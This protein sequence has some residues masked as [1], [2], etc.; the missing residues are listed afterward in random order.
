[1]APIR[2]VVQRTI[3]SDTKATTRSGVE[4]RTTKSVRR[5]ARRVPCCI[6]W[7]RAYTGSVAVP[8]RR[9][10]GRKNPSITN[11]A[12]WYL[13]KRY[14]SEG[15]TG[16]VYALQKLPP[17]HSAESVVDALNAAVAAL[18]PEQSDAESPAIWDNPEELWVTHNAQICPSTLSTATE[19][20]S[21]TASPLLDLSTFPN[22]DASRL[23]QAKALFGESTVETKHLSQLQTCESGSAT[24]DNFL[25][26]LPTSP[27]NLF[28]PILPVSTDLDVKSCP[29][30]LS[31]VPD[32]RYPPFQNDRTQSQPQVRR[33]VRMEDLKARAATLPQ[34]SVNPPQRTPTCLRVGSPITG[35]VMTRK[36]LAK[37]SLKIRIPKNRNKE[38]LPRSLQARDDGSALNPGPDVEK[39]CVI[40]AADVVKDGFNSELEPLDSDLGNFTCDFSSINSRDPSRARRAVVQGKKSKESTTLP[41]KSGSS[42]S[43]LASTSQISI[44][45]TNCS[46]RSS[47]KKYGSSRH[48]DT[49]K[50]LPPLP[51]AFESMKAGHRDLESVAMSNATLK[52]LLA[53]ECDASDSKKEMEERIASKRL[54]DRS[55]AVIQGFR[56]FTHRSF[57]PL[58]EDVRSQSDGTLWPQAP[59]Q[60]RAAD[61][62]GVQKRAA[63]EASLA[64]RKKKGRGIIF[65]DDGPWKAV[66]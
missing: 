8:R 38:S 45:Q 33:K 17:S 58:P 55:A 35:P 47:I 16:L 24:A 32:S 11:T 5:R 13:D 44:T 63:S 3:S 7:P 66:R 14:P 54:S 50:D 12:Q 28:A 60:N 20:T 49:T 18:E 34:L 64:I 23:S 36:P 51:N 48:V 10:G 37:D 29:D 9:E 40:T 22:T 65:A 56:D 52:A 61:L 6:P 26:S 53:A 30:Q 62:S 57:F 46:S 25:S 1:M 31:C 41:S 15:P 27:P 21:T 59:S 2:K 43:D 19:N 39:K 4:R 42:S